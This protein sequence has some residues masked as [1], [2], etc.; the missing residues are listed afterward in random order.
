MIMGFKKKIRLH[1]LLSITGWVLC[2]V[3]VFLILFAILRWE[4]D[5]NGEGYRL[6][7]EGTTVVD[8]EVLTEEDLTVVIPEGITVIGERA[9]KEAC[10]NLK[11]VVFPESLV[12]IEYGAFME[13]YK[14]TSVAF[15]D[16]LA[17]IA[18]SAFYR[19]MWLSNV[20]SFEGRLYNGREYG[21]EE[22]EELV[23]LVTSRNSE[24]GITV[25]S[26]AKP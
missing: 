10:N 24:T 2:A 23:T 8:I 5:K 6:I 18:P 7:T 21:A 14:L 12:V 1:V 26:K 11:A 22:Q 16:S 19:C 3:S 25:S 9:F 13:C 4:S 15:P 17:Y 20:E